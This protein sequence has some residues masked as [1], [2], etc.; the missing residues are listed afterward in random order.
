MVLYSKESIYHSVS[1]FENDKI[2][3][4]NPKIRSSILYEPLNMQA[5]K[6]FQQM[7][8]FIYKSKESEY[9]EKTGNNVSIEYGDDVFYD[10]HLDDHG[11]ITQH[12][13]GFT[14]FIVLLALFCLVFITFWVFKIICLA[15]KKKKKEEKKNEEN[16]DVE[17]VDIVEEMNQSEEF[18][19]EEEKREEIVEKKETKDKLRGKNQSKINSIRI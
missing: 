9:E 19:D 16:N 3:F 4:Q 8:L 1:Y 18:V 14:I 7:Y 13:V 12:S 2:N 5:T 15:C 17:K 6:D 10:V 11:E